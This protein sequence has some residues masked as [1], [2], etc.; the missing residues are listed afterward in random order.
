MHTNMNAFRHT[1]RSVVRRGTVAVV[2]FAAGVGVAG[3]QTPQEATTPAS[4]V[5]VGASVVSD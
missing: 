4:S 1:V 2:A 5:E 3:A